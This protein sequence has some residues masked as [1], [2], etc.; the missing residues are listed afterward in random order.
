MNEATV[1]ELIEQAADRGYLLVSEL[2][3]VRDPARHGDGWTEQIA[4]LVRDH[5]VTVVDDVAGEEPSG[6]VKM[7]MSGDPVRQY[8]DAAGRHDLLDAQREQDLAKRYQ[9]GLAAARLLEDGEALSPRRRALLHNV[10]RDG[11]RAKDEMV[12]SNLR[13]VVPQAKKWI[14]RGVDFIELIQE[15]NLG[16]IRAVEKFD[17]TKGYK[18][19]TYAVWWIRQSLQRGFAD[20][21]RTIRVPA[22]V[23][24]LSAKL[25]RA[26]IDLRQELGRDPIDE[27]ISARSRIDLERIHEVRDVLQDLTSLDRPVGEDGDASMGDLIPDAEAS[28]PEVTASA[29]DA[30]TRIA[31]VLGTLD[32][33]ERSILEL[34]FGFV[35]G[36]TR[37][38]DEI[39][40]MYGLSRERIRQVEKEALAKLRH[41][42]SGTS[43]NSLLDAVAAA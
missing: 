34:R 16:L 13:L 32:E 36:D 9:A 7:T 31:G 2:E 20:K 38:L 35:D 1:A 15:G 40:Q 18:F 23:W 5:D 24:E 25:R 33:R 6:E 14:G 17:H 29:I 4:S 26:E 41:P 27:E 43:L 10:R 30:R 42:A 3:E 22:H 11:E 28:D 8:L 21:A 19:S 37:T 12:R 39:A